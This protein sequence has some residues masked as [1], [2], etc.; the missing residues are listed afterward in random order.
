[1]P[2]YFALQERLHHEGLEE[3]AALEF[4]TVPALVWLE[5][6]GM[7]IDVAGWTALRDRACADQER[8]AREIAEQLPGVNLNSPRQL[9]AALADLGIQ[10][11]NAQEG[12]LRE[13]VGAHPVVGLLLAHKEAT[14]RVGTYGEGYL[15][16][17]HPATGRIHADYHQI[18]AETGRMACARPNLQ[19]IP[20]DP[21]YRACIRPAPGRVLV[22][23]DLALI[24]LC[25]AAELAG[26]ERM[27][28]AITTGT[29]CIASRRRPFSTR[30]RSA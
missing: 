16:A 21:A 18:G 25:A 27:L 1:V 28:K 2:L 7:P 17:V 6:T 8:L 9:I 5:Q 26:D 24:E 11:P 12:T 4:S 30:L 3:I 14:K 19:N 20:R 29:I 13:M 23:A 15:A 22:K 10:V